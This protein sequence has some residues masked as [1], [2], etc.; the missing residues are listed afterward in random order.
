MAVFEALSG[1]RTC[2]S[3]PAGW[4]RPPSAHW[5]RESLMPGRPLRG[6]NLPGPVD[7]YL[8]PLS[9][10]RVDAHKHR[11]LPV[12]SSQERFDDFTRTF[13]DPAAWARK[14]HLV[15]V[16]GDRGYGKT[17]LIQRCV[18]WLQEQ[19]APHCKMVVVDLSDERWSLTETEED[20]RR[21]TLD[22]IL[23]TLRR[24]LQADQVAQIKN[25]ADMMESFRD[26][27]RVLSTR[28]DGSGNALP[29]IVVAVLLQ[30]YPRPSELE[31][32]Y[33][34]ARPGMF[35]FAEIF[36]HEDI[37]AVTAMIP[38][39]NRVSTDARAL[40]LDVLKPG[41]A[42]LLMD[43][44]RRQGGGWPVVPDDIVR[45]YF[46]SIIQY[47]VAM[48][49]LAKLTWGTLN[50]AAAEAATEVTVSHVARYYAQATFVGNG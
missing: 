9:P 28:A 36:D 26:L 4:N 7:E 22:W 20:R 37:T 3:R 34:L 44:I 21:R 10:L 29:P 18:S 49:E 35:F 27:G 17:S 23:D 31:Q 40:P 16:T 47:R 43:W 1:R 24:D 38:R 30:G 11:Y 5:R 19:A 2:L 6:G 15:V 12:D 50:V 46:D 33:S 8:Q 41:D 45:E 14:G 42:D 25:H 39:F 48:A 32:Y 13:A